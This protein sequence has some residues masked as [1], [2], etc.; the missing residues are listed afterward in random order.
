MVND[1]FVVA[2]KLHLAAVVE[3]I[4]SRMKHLGRLGVSRIHIVTY[5]QVTHRRTILQGELRRGCL[6]AATVTRMLR[7][8][9]C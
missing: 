5:L 1:L 2:G 9:C 6:S 3:T 7:Y 4:G 8:V